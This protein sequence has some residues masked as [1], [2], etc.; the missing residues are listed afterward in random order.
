MDGLGAGGRQRAEQAAVEGGLEGHDGELRRAGALVV[1]GRLELLLGE[2]DVRATALLLAP[3]HEGSLV[4]G[5]VGVGS[6]HCREDLVQSWR[7]HLEDTG[8][9]DVS[10]IVG[11][12]IAECWPVDEGAGHLG[13]FR[14][15]L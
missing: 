8:L 3:P 6:G 12:E 4:G 13:A 10:P 5:L 2:L 11:R 9:E 7:G 1:H 15:L 14:D